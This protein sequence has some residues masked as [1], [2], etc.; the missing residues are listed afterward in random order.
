MSASQFDFL[1]SF[2]KSYLCGMLGKPADIGFDSLRNIVY[3][4]VGKCEKR[5]KNIIE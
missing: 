5:L 1:C 3:E 4:K 2:Q